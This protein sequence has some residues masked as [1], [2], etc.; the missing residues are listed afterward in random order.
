MLHLKGCKLGAQLFFLWFFPCEYVYINKGFLISLL[1]ICWALVICTMSGGG[2]VLLDFSSMNVYALLGFRYVWSA[3]G[4]T[5]EMKQNPSTTS[6]IHCITVCVCGGLFWKRA[7]DLLWN[8]VQLPK[9][10]NVVWWKRGKRAELL[11]EVSTVFSYICVTAI[12]RIQCDIPPVAQF[13]P[14]SQ[15]S[16]TWLS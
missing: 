11:W 16:V 3:L 1:C 12:A 8:R 15:R 7:G 13:L 14:K 4:E 6:Y 2:I 10:V 5:T 9:P